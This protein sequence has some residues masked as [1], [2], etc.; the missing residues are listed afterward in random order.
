M[1]QNKAR[2]NFH[3][4]CG[5]RHH[6]S[7]ANNFACIMMCFKSTGAAPGASTRFAFLADPGA[8]IVHKNNTAIP[9][10]SAINN[11]YQVCRCAPEQFFRTV[12][13]GAA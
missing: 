4:S 1:V 6:V 5:A 7:N 12:R 9:Y 8:P 3:S 11:R 10:C 13:R 2:L